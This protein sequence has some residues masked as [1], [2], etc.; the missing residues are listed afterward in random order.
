MAGAV[1]GSGMVAQPSALGQGTKAVEAP[2]VQKWEYRVVYAVP[3]KAQKA[4]D[5]LAEQGF[6]MSNFTVTTGTGLAYHF[7]FKRAKPQQGQ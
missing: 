2:S 4:V 3:D 5:S 7:V 6:E 1:I